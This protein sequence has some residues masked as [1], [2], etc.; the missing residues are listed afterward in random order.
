[1]TRQNRL[2]RALRFVAE[3]RAGQQARFWW[4]IDVAL[5]AVAG[6]SA[7]PFYAHNHVHPPASAVPV[8]VAVAAP[9]VV[10]RAF[11]VP[12][13][14]WVLCSSAVAGLWNEHLVPAL[15]VVIALYTVASLRPRRDAL[16]AAVALECGSVGAAIW[17]SGVDFWYDSIFLSGLVAAAVGLGLYTGTRRAYL[18]ELRD[19]AERLKQERDQQGALAAAAERARITRE[20]HDIVAHHLTVMVALSDGAVAVTPGSP[21]RGV[22]VMRTVSETGRRA[23]TDTRRL[24]GILRQDNDEDRL[25]ALHPVPDLIGL[26]ELLE[27]VRSAGLPTTFEVQGAPA[28]VP[29]GMQSTVYRIVQEALT[30]TLKHGGTGA[31]ASVRL[32]YLPGGELRV[33]VTD[34]GAGAAAPPSAAVGS[35]VRGMQERVHAYGG[36]L[37]AGPGQAGGWRVS[38]RMSLDDAGEGEGA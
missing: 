34:D 6:A 9:L 13:F 5:A 21:A 8:L 3:D 15:A 27:R 23:L 16:L 18:T 29:A 32:R 11:P 30:N 37:V 33:D 7:L 10:R 22:E 12:V 4:V 35:G 36:D 17:V 24:L 2:G 20:M 1:M 26:D 14:I 31:R 19:R 38:A 28:E 25:D